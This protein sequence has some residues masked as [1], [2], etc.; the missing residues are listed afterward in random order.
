VELSERGNG[1]ITVDLDRQYDDLVHTDAT[2]FLRPKT[3]LKDMFIELMPGTGTAPVAKEGWQMPLANTLPDVNP[4]EF[5]SALDSDTRDYLRLL[6]NGARGGLEGR[7]HDLE[8]VLKRFEPTYRDIAAVSG[9]VAK[10]REDLERLVHALDDLNTELGNADDDLAELVGASARTFEAFASE[11][12]NIAATVR[13]LPSTLRLTTEALGRVERMALV[14]RPAADIIRRP[15]RALRRANAE[16]LPF[17]REVAPLLRTDI[18]P[19]VREAR[20]FL[21]EL[22]PATHDLVEA[23]PGLM[24]TVRALNGLFNL[25]GYNDKGREGPEVADRDEG[26]LFYLAWLAHQSI[27]LF[28]G[29]DAHGVFRPLVLGGTCNVIKASSATIPGGDVLLGTV[30]VLSDPNVCGTPQP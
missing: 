25:L 12:D 21:R 4:D 28:S 16:T 3:G 29:Q 30:G 2:A 10:R 23:D 26:Y 15:V 17:A 20:P 27:Q 9:E 8:Q 11:H 13:E 1:V 6:L 5:L 22:K 18:R 24:G 7:A 14:L 19:F